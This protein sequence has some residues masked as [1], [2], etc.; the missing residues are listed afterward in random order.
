MT[1]SSQDETCKRPH[2][3]LNHTLFI[4]LNQ[5]ESNWSS[6]VIALAQL[7]SLF[8]AAAPI[9]LNEHTWAVD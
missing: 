4:K 5:L 6:N 1:F 7:N 9:H 8:H 2:L 3:Y